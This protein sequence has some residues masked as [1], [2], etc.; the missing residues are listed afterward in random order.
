MDIRHITLY[1]AGLI[2]TGWASYLISRGFR[3]VRVYDLD[4]DRLAQA[5][6]RIE[7]QLNFL[8]SED[9]V[10]P[11]QAEEGLAALRFT[12]DPE[13]ALK[14]ADLIQENGPEH[15]DIKRS[16]LAVIEKHCPPDAL[17]CT[18]TSG[19]PLKTIIEGAV[20]P[21][22]IVGA[23]PYHPVYLLPLVELAGGEKTKKEYLE[24]A[25]D[26]FESIGKVVVTLKKESPGYIAS[27]LMSA[28]FRECV[29]LISQG[30][31]TMEDI[32]TAFCYGPGL[33]YA[34]MGPCTVLQLAGGDA[35]IAG[36]LFGGIGHSGDNWLESFANWT[37]YPPETGPFFR[38]CQQ[39][40][41]ENLARRDPQHGRNN[42]EIELFRDRGLAGLLRHHGM[43]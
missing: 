40:M 14:D 9:I 39:Q 33:R 26:F 6:A 4:E 35:G 28:L 8:S 32:D 31:C 25:K 27:H 22:R 17:I 42:A 10:T 7:D 19:I 38:S 34:L 11:A 23:H 12:A 37:V 24:R 43:L 15:P 20:N 36:T 3:D 13:T 16:I 21:G 41:N 29:N 1:G 5:R 18:S 30:V 2:G